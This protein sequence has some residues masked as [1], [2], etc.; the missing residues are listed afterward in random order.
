MNP[1][2]SATRARAASWQAQPEEGE[3]AS[4]EMA[5]A[6]CTVATTIS[7]AARSGQEVLEQHPPAPATAWRAPPRVKLLAPLGARRAV[8]PN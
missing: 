2:G 7:G 5:E 4:S 3:R 6:T 1:F 8:A